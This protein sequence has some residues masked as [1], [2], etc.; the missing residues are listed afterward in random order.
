M[1]L[2]GP[3]LGV[4]AE[5]INNPQVLY[6]FIRGAA[7]Q[8]GARWWADISTWNRFGNKQPYTPSSAAHRPAAVPAH[9]VAG[10]GPAVFAGREPYPGAH[11]FCDQGSCTCPD[12]P[13]A[14]CP[15]VSTVGISTATACLSP[16]CRLV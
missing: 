7:R 4:G 9:P 16:R 8:Y 3:T 1:P 2:P 15:S 13:N 10:P 11:Q 5:G 6:A 14:T 12:G